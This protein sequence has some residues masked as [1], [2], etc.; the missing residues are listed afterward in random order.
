MQA[1]RYT[2]THISFDGVINAKDILSSF[3][4]FI[5]WGIEWKSSQKYITLHVYLRDD[6]SESLPGGCERV[7]YDVAG[8]T[9]GTVLI[10]ILQPGQQFNLGVGS[11]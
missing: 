4:D 11:E 5:D 7:Q 9:E 6:G 2:T 1:I 3:P 10:S 8:G